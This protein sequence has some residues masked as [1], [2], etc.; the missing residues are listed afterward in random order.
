[1]DSALEATIKA[2]RSSAPWGLQ[3]ISQ[4][5]SI[6]NTA[7]PS[8]TSYTYTYSSTALGSGV[9][10]YIVRRTPPRSRPG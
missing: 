9:D 1:M 7:S 4:T 5:D 10:I 8:S 6:S 2:T 3:R